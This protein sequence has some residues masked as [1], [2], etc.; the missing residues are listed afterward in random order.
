RVGIARALSVDPEFIICDEPVTALDVSIQAQIINL[1]LSLQEKL[2]LSYLFI[3]HDLSVVKHMS[4]RI[5]V[6][7]LGWIMEI[8]DTKTLF[9][10]PK[11][12]YTQALLDAVPRLEPEGP[13]RKVL[14]GE[15]PS[16]I[17][18]PKGC[19]FHPRCPR[20]IGKVC[21]EVEPPNVEMPDGSMV[22]CHLYV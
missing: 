21:E 17:D 10:N 6:M 12:P 1:L 3:A 16:P 5:A 9:S 19:R 14:H 4:D 8:A 20:K 7:Y 22:K 11:H 13:K 15:V 18:P 2:K